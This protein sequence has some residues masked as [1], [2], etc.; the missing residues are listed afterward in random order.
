M[1]IREQ[2]RAPAIVFAVKAVLLAGAVL[3]FLVLV[4]WYG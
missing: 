4:P 3:V 2:L 1:K